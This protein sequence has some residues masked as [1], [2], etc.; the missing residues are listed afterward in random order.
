MSAVFILSGISS[1]KEVSRTLERKTHTFGGA[2]SKVAP[3][4]VAWWLQFG[5]DGVGVAINGGGGLEEWMVR[6]YKS[7]EVAAAVHGGSKLSGMAFV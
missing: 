4:L 6:V 7:D 2:G 3:L 5:S 1:S